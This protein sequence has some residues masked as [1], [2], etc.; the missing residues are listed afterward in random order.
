M[1]R[2][3]VI[4]SI[5][6]AD[7]LTVNFERGLNIITGETGAGK[8]ILV[9]ALALLRGGRVETSLIRSGCDSAQVS[10]VFTL[11]ADSPVFAILGEHGIERDRE[12]P[13][14][15]LLRRVIQRNGRHRAFLNDVPV[16]SRTLQS[17]A[18]QLID[19]SSQFENQ[20]LLD[21]QSHTAYL[22]IFASV[23]D[24]CQKVAALYDD[25]QGSLTRIRELERERERRRREKDLYEF[26][27]K[28]IE[29][30]GP[31]A[32]EFSEI[33]ELLNIGRK[34]AHVENLCRETLDLLVESDSSV[35][36]LLRQVR[37]NLEKLEKMSEGTRAA[38]SA[39]DADETLASLEGVVARVERLARSFSVDEDKLAWAQERIE[40]YNKL[41]RK[42]GQTIEGVVRH[43]DMCSDYLR[44]VCDVDS[45]IEVL[46]ERAAKV[47][48]DLISAAGELT[49]K[50]TFVP[51]DLSSK[52]QKELAELGMQKARFRCV[53]SERVPR[54]EDILPA[55]VFEALT[56]Q[57]R[58]LFLKVS[59]Q[60]FEEVRFMLSANAGME[61]QAIEKVASG[62]E[63]SRVMLAIKTILYSDESVSLFV[64]DEID[65]GISGGIASKV[66]RKLA[67]FCAAR[68]AI[69]I[70]HLPQVA[71]YAVNHFVA[72][73]EVKSGKT[74]ANITMLRDEDR[75]HELAVMLSGEKVSA[76]G[77]AQARTLLSEARALR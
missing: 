44:S 58:D 24:L 10:G 19:I 66:G 55:G 29:E 64:F 35:H 15:I 43:R 3:I 54:S 6:I 33:E 74:I 34:T 41:L 62:G 72:K 53:F 61:P 31:D 25:S 59:R 30:A 65:T 60:G 9:D 39:V 38:V 47:V 13:N 77:I 8:S 50:R 37:R 16:N 14:D 11:C 45:E 71:C 67:Q 48:R 22:D 40:V 56:Q 73:K 32:D 27:L 12:C 28:E 57:E 51:D 23:T 17:V 7:N 42:Y 5:A 46:N 49:K 4:Q 75:P 21:P 1:I 69:C 52:V 76:E 2:Q 20:R 36:S 18:E 63:L 68:Q 26:E 70:T